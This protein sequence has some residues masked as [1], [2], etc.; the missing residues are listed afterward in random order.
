MRDE[1]LTI[2]SSVIFELIAPDAPVVPVEVELA[3]SSRDP[4]A[5]QASFRTGGESSVNWVF[6]RD[7]LADGLVAPAGAGD[8]KVQPVPHDLG[9][10]ELELTSPSGHA[11]F[12][13]CA[14]RLAEFLDRTFEVVP[15][16]SEYS[17]LD[18]DAALS[19]LLAN[20]RARD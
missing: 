7:L 2:C 15:A 11:V 14:A 17:W 10:I 6:A 4:Y 16:G 1:Y 5:V 12:T 9:R 13:T 18:F 19:N 3:Y 8:V 20:D